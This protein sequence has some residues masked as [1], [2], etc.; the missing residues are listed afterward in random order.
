MPKSLVSR[1]FHAPSLFV[2][3]VI[4]ALSYNFFS[5]ISKYSTNV[6]FFDQW[7]FL[8]L[9]FNGQATLTGLFLAQHGPH[10]EGVGLWA[11]KA[12][13]ALTDWNVRAESFMIGGSV[14][15]A[16]LL[17]LWVKKRLFGGLSYSDVSIPLMFLTL[18]QD[19]ALIGT[20]NPAYGGFPL[21]MILLYC[22]ALLQR[23]SYLRYGLILIINFCLIYTGFGVFMGIVTIGVC[24][25]DCYWR[26]RRIT[27]VPAALPAVALLIAVASLGSFFL[28]YTFVSA[29]DCFEF[30]RRDLAA[31]PKYMPVMFA[32][33]GGLKTPIL[34]ATLAGAAITLVSAMVLAV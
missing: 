10:R 25:L 31:Y 18:A 17:A 33:F 8:T 15:V 14:F 28:R 3:A 11:D 29:V 16:M 20:P 22:V 26:L 13:Y 24:A 9:F 23:N 4:L 34:M 19:E 2:A 21:A 1:A 32:N 6:L 5:F 12:L 7:D 27:S 30:P